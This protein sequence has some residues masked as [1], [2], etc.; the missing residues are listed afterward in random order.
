MTL[1]TID[2]RITAFA[3]SVRSHLDDLPAED[4]DD[5]VEGL[6]ADLAEQAA[7]SGEDFEI[8][9]APAYAD[10]LRAA[11]GFPERATSTR[12]VPMSA[13]FAARRAAA[14]RS[15]R[16][17]PLGAWLLDLALVLRPV[18]WIAR[19][20]A[21]Y[22]LLT[23][24]VGSGPMPPTILH[25]ALLLGSVLL[26]IQWGRDRWM[27]LPWL[28]IVRTIAGVVAAIT[29]PIALVAFSQA[30]TQSQN[31][32]EYVDSSQPG[33][34]VDGERVRNIFAYD[35]DGRPI[36]AVQ[37]FD[38]DGRPLTTVGDQAQYEDWQWDYY[39]YAGYGS[40]PVPVPYTETG[41]APLWNV[42]PLSE[43]S[44]GVDGDLDP[45]DALVPQHPFVQVPA[46]AGTDDE[47]TDAATQPEPSPMSTDLAETPA[48]TP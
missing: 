38:Q 36:E 7:E 47:S 37:L 13:R 25:W 46:V 20:W 43:A 10:E 4:V 24:W 6:E 45:A 41:R 8:P 15:L 21:I 44:V 32:V 23:F 3:A 39:F 40:G 14:S 22:F 17:H 35:Q 28:R 27:P 33:L 5:L 2:E 9:D 42:F 12:R 30:V 26:S 11:A 1:A 31:M 18:W 19:G 34:T 48:P 29:L 16:T